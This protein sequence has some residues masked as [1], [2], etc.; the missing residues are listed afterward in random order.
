MQVCVCS[1]QPEATVDVGNNFLV[2]DAKLFRRHVFPQ[3]PCELLMIL[4]NSSILL[5]KQHE[6]FSHEPDTHHVTG[7]C[8][9]RRLFLITESNFTFISL[10]SLKEFRMRIAQQNILC[11]WCQH[12]ACSRTQNTI[13][14]FLF[15]KWE[16]FPKK[17]QC[18]IL[19]HV[20][21]WRF[22]AC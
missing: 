8:S 11:G 20:G 22:R 14:L 13:L 16:I 10:I 1:L 17:D 3:W 2:E 5:K 6:W 18:F 21:L 15:L 7:N 4:S 9:F 12:S 19:F